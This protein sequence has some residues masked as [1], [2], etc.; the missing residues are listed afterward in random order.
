[1]LPVLGNRWLH[2]QAVAAKAR[3]AAAAVSP[4]DRDLLV[5]A[6]WAHDIGYAPGLARTGFHPIDGAR[7]VRQQGHEELARIV[8]Y[9][10]GAQFEAEERGM[11]DDLAEFEPVDGPLIDALIYADMTTGPAGQ[12]FT[13]DERIDEILSRYPADDPVHRAISRSRPVLGEAI[14]R[15]RQRLV[16]SVDQPM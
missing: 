14:E 7:Y 9:H 13:F 2:V 8:A 12:A 3:E 4:E 6:A 10:S 1:M 5:A 11:V 16:A 15:I